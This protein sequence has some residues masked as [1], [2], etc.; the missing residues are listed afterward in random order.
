MPG[1]A[2]YLQSIG[3]TGTE[4]LLSAAGAAGATAVLVAEGVTLAGAILLRDR[5]RTSAVEAL[6]K[7]CDF[8]LTDQRLLTGDNRR[9]AEVIA[10]EAGIT[11]VQAEL[12]PAQKVD[13][14]KAVIASGR[15]PVMIGEG[16]N[17]AA[18]L[19]SADVG[20]AVS[21]ASD[22]AAEAADVVYLPKSLESLPLF[23]LVSRKAVRT[24]WQNIILFAGVL[25]ACA[26][27]L[28]ATG[29][30]GPVGAAVTHQLSSF[31][32]M[33][34]SPRLLRVPGRG[35]PAWWKERARAIVPAQF[36]LGQL[37]QRVN[38][39][40]EHLEFDGLAN[41]FLRS[42]PRLRR[43]LLFSAAALYLL[44]GIYTLNPDE[45]GIVERFGR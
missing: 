3:V 12:L 35:K 42:W 33:L 29:K 1:S 26:V 22:I 6:N 25:N 31:F 8:G 19:A 27:L 21:G 38:A 17:D 23:L 16:L 2:A 20:I 37:S 7:L 13:A 15:H 4:S 41:S 28:A 9:A 39:F 5:L 24:A 11:E 10:R 14:V 34:N 44:S 40:A 36:T 30:L 32:V 43:P 18:A 45:I